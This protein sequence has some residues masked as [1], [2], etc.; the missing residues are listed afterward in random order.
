MIG[1]YCFTNKINNKKYI[2]QSVDIKQRW[3]LHKTSAFSPDNKDYNS[4]FHNA[5]R[6]Y[7]WDNFNKEVLTECTKEEL[8]E[9][10]KYY[11]KKFDTCNRENGYN[12]TYGGD[13]S[14]HIDTYKDN[15]LS[16]WNK[17]LKCIEISKEVGLSSYTISEKLKRY[18]I[19]SEEILYRSKNMKPVIQLTLDGIEIARFKSAKEASDITHI[20]KGHIIDV[21]NNKRKQTCGYKW[22]YII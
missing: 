6:K 4:Y 18:G 22:Q 21:C 12:L 14:I 10:E 5:L 1:I 20:N 7:G 17:G 19:S 8:N 16:L 2:G 15:I 3:R 9:L 11:I 13:S